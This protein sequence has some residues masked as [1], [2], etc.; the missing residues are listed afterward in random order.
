[1]GKFSDALEKSGVELG[2][3][4]THGSVQQPP[5]GTEQRSPALH[6]STAA[7][8][9]WD[10]RL[11][12][13]LNDSPQAAESFRIL[14][15]RILFPPDGEQPPRTIMVTSCSAMEGKSF[16]SANLAVAMAQGLDQHALLVDCDL[17]RPTLAKMF[18]LDS[19]CRQGLSDYLRKECEL[20]ELIYKTSVDKLSILAS[21]ELPVNPAELLTSARMSRLVQE[22]SGRYRDRFIIF[23]SPPFQ[24]ASESQ[25][26]AKEVDGV[27]LVVGYGKSDRSRIKA[28][29]QQIGREKIVGVV[30]NGMQSSYLK[31]KM[32][33]AYGSYGSYYEAQ[34]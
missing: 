9:P 20:A 13:V 1:M 28:M 25:V 6:T 31:D 27:V 3:K 5:A 22:L 19:L 30:F 26:L 11:T 29:L 17:R 14:R 2:D 16:V 12:K 21:G 23:D 18:G 34:T 4:P 33:D 10:E 15:S 8:G 32:F 24:V 7:F